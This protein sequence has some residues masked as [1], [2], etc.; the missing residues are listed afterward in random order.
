MLVDS[1][2]APDCRV[3]RHSHEHAYFCVNHGGT[4]TEAYGRRQRRCAPGMLVFH[5]P[6]EAHSEVTGSTPVASLNVEIGASWLNRIFDLAGPLDQ[7]AEFCGGQIADAGLQL[8]RE[9]QRDDVDSALAI[10]SLCCEILAATCD[11]RRPPGDTGAPRWMR[12]ARDLLDASLGRSPTLRTVAQEVSV[13]PVHLAATFRRFHG[14]SVG[15][16]LRRQRLQR[17]RRKLA[18]LELS[19]ADIAIESGFAD[20]SHFTR[21]FKRYTGVT[22]AVYRT[23]LPFKTR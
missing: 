4:Y 21:T 23:F 8:L 2:H 22:P 18:N 17:A 16:Y 1:L 12:E 10:E 15:E 13:H 9:L 20:Q 7:P 14:C 3:P 19:L 11:H 5:P 6:G